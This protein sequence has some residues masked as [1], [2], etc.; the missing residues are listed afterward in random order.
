M[1]FSQWNQT[2]FSKF[3]IP[4]IWTLHFTKKPQKLKKKKKF[5]TIIRWTTAE[6]P[7]LVLHFR[8][9]QVARPKLSLVF[10]SDWN[11]RFLQTHIN[12][13]ADLH[14]F[15]S[16]YYVFCF[17]CMGLGKKQILF[18]ISLPSNSPMWLAHASNSI[19]VP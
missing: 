18:N 3:W 10:W 1:P 11:K 5:L 4:K 19:E 16:F 7:K 12:P 2:N 8:T 17:V 14:L 13:N 9:L 6:F 15:L